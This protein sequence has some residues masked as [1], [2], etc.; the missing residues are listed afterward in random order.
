MCGDRPHGSKARPHRHLC[1]HAITRG[2]LKDAAASKR[3]RHGE[4][5][6]VLNTKRPQRLRDGPPRRIRAGPRCRCQRQRPPFREHRS[7]GQPRRDLPHRDAIPEE[8]HERVDRAREARH[9]CH[10]RWEP[11][12]LHEARCFVPVVMNRHVGRR[13]RRSR[14]RRG[15]ALRG[16]S[17]KR[18]PPA[19][20]VQ[21]HLRRQPRAPAA[22]QACRRSPDPG[23]P[24][25]DRRHRHPFL[26]P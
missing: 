9:E 10:R 20:P 1:R 24:C 11:R 25:A 21:R 18:H 4:R 26:I 2:S 19:A 17:S 5:G 12:P 13:G 3:G 23:A 15:R 14:R 16:G 8:R 7:T 6:I 22:I